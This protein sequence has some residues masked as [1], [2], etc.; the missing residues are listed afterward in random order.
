MRRQEDARRSIGYIAT[1]FMKLN[2]A[3]L[4]ITTVPVLYVQCAMC[5][6]DT[7]SLPVL[8]YTGTVPVLYI[9]YCSLRWIDQAVTLA[10]QKSSTRI[11]QVQY[12]YVYTGTAR[13]LVL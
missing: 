9:D 7:C 5:N 4:Y 10:L 12:R 6:H 11:I 8:I 13:V 2:G 1:E 3:I